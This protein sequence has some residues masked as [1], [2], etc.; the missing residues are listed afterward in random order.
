LNNANLIFLMVW[1]RTRS[2]ESLMAVSLVVILVTIMALAPVK[3]EL[4]R[5]LEAKR[6][7]SRDSSSDARQS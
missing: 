1:P 3:L 4:D 6:A 7:R 2:T 5:A